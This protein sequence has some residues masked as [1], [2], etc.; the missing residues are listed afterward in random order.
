MGHFCIKKK[1]KTDG[2]YGPSLK[3]T[4]KQP[5]P[6]GMSRVQLNSTAHHSSP[7]SDDAQPMSPA[8]PIGSLGLLLHASAGC[9]KFDGLR[10]RDR[11]FVQLPSFIIFFTPSHLPSFLKVLRWLWRT[12]VPPAVW[13]TKRVIFFCTDVFFLLLLS[14]SLGIPFASNS[15]SIQ[16][17]V[18]EMYMT[19]SHH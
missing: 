2:T 8:A 6:E 11:R 3:T 17:I 16:F 13:E 12:G 9:Q 1:K 18:N 15:C 4:C 10:V 7:Q 19:H 5:F 14:F